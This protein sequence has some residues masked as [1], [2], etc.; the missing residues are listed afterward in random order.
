MKMKKKNRKESA[1]HLDKFIFFFVSKMHL[2]E[3]EKK[4]EQ[5]SLGLM[6][7]MI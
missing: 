6:M 7:I 5:Q 3:V 2:A 1:K 4:G